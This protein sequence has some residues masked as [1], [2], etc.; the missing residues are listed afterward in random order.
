MVVERCC[1]NALRE[2]GIAMLERVKDITSLVRDIGVIV[3][4]PTIITVGMS[5]YDIQ[6]KALDRQVKANEAQIRAL[7]SQNNVLRE[8]QFDRA[9]T[10][11]KSQ[12]ETYD[13]ER[14]DLEKKINNLRRS[15]DERVASLEAR[16]RETTKNLQTSDRT[17]SVLGTARSSTITVGISPEQIIELLKPLQDLTEGQKEMI[18]RLQSD[19][20]LNE[21]QMRNALD[22]VGETNIPPERLAAKLV[23]IAEKFND[24]ESAITAQPGVSRCGKAIRKA[25][26]W[27][28]NLGRC[29]ALLGL[30]HKPYSVCPNQ[31]IC[32]SILSLKRRGLR[33]VASNAS[34]RRRTCRILMKPVLGV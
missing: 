20:D 30:R 34:S 15:G 2:I 7:E 31:E 4:V 23:E 14:V 11:I 21:H 3:G 28:R 6:S 1:G 5:L 29:L 12:R 13:L 18:S 33:D 19:L 25:G 27:C 9:L 32:T 8:T 26:D 22:I 10:I 16:L 24:L 17:I